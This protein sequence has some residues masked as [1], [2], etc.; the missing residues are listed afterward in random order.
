MEIL[1]TLIALW[2]VPGFIA[3]CI[4]SWY[5]K[6]WSFDEKDFV[7]LLPIVNIVMLAFVILITA[8]SLLDRLI[9]WIYGNNN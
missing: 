1:L 4:A 8:E 6:N 9:N 3:Y 7:L 2:L 5:N